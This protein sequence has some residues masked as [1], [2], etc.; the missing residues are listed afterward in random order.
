MAMEGGLGRQRGHLRCAR[1]CNAAVGDGKVPP[2]SD[3]MGMKVM[4]RR[5]EEI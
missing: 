3:A 1:N 5:E 4:K 2:N